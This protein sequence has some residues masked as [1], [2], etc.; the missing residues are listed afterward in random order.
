MRTVLIVDDSASVRAQVAE[1][2]GAAGYLVV[3]AED[4]LDALAKLAATQDVGLVVCDVNMPNLNGF[5][6]IERMK[7]DEKSIP[8]VMLTSEGQ[9]AL[10]ARARKAGAKGWIVKP[11]KSE[12]LVAAVRKLLSS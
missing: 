3:E 4:G 2:L 5:D 12:L 10:I 7:A 6:M 11:F 8:V 1:V 9:P